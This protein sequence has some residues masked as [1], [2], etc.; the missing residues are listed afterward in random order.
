[1]VEQEQE[2]CSESWEGKANLLVCWHQKPCLQEE[3]LNC[4][5]QVPRV[6]GYCLAWSFYQDGQ[7]SRILS[8]PEGLE[9]LTPLGPVE[10]GAQLYD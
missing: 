4:V 3:V 10:M 9:V 1:M 7:G 6:P 2:F 5:P 8:I